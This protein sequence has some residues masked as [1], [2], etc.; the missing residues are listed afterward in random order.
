MQ[1]IDRLRSLRGSRLRDKGSNLK[2]HQ[3]C[4]GPSKLTMALQIDRATID[5][6]DMCSSEKLWVEENDGEG[7]GEDWE[8]SGERVIACKRVGVESAGEDWA[9]RSLRFY[10][11][12]SPSV[13]VRDRQAERAGYTGVT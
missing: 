13:S 11:K 12:D 1:G 8:V 3:L 2:L 5:G 4:N 7:V 9:G 10:M 6:L